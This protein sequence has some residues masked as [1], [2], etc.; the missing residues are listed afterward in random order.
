MPQLGISTAMT[1]EPVCLINIGPR[2]QARRT[3]FGRVNLSITAV[4]TAVV[5]G[6]GASP[7]WLPAVFV[8]AFLAGLGFVQAR[9]RT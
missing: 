2:G 4:T 6:L 9:A 1:D 8:P 5:A 7:A 3:R